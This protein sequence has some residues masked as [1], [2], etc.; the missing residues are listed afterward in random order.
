MRRRVASLA[1]LVAFA[2]VVGSAGA[3]RAEDSDVAQELFNL[4]VADLKQERYETACAA[5]EKSYGLDGNIGTLIALGDCFERWGKLHS[6]ATHFEA[7]IARVSG[8]GAATSVHRAGQLEYAETALARITPKI[9]ELELIYPTPNDPALRVLLDGRTL[10][11]LPAGASPSEQGARVDPGHHVIETQAPGRAPWRVEL[12]L[13]AGERRRVPLERGPAPEPEPPTAS[14]ASAPPI[15]PVP[16]PERPAPP[17][18]REPEPETN[19]WRTVGWGLGGLGLAGVGVGTVAGVLVL[20]ECPAFR[21]PAHA[22]RGQHL[23]LVTDIGFGVG[24]TALAA[25]VFLLLST[26][27][28]PSRIDAARRAEEAAWRPLGAVDARGGWLGVSHDF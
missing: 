9:P 14:T 12:D 20:Q 1:S 8:A 27:A 21:C 17:P 2:V 7:L 28:P 13:S 19:P 23:A 3:A 26:D 22:E 6:A 16:P 11:A 4:G 18:R 15:A 24:L 25:S 5:L 10:D